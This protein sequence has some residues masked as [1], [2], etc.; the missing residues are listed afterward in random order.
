ME[1]NNNSLFKVLFREVETVRILRPH[2]I[3]RWWLSTGYIL[4]GILGTMSAPE[5]PLSEKGAAVYCMYW[6]GK[7]KQLISSKVDKDGWEKLFVEIDGRIDI[8]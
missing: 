6:R 3:S 7:L 4:S 8:S 5:R 2:R 1:C